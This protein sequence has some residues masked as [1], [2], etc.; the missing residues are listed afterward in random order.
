[1]NEAICEY[2]SAAKPVW[3]TQRKSP[4]LSFGPW[5]AVR[6][7]QG[8]CTTYLP[9][10]FSLAGKGQCSGRLWRLWLVCTDWSKQR[11]CQRGYE[12][13]F[14]QKHLQQNVRSSSSAC[15]W[16]VWVAE[17][18]LDMAFHF[19]HR[20]DFFYSGYKFWGVNWCTLLPEMRQ[21]IT[22]SSSS[23][24]STELYKSVCQ[25]GGDPGPTELNSGK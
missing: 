10:A 25:A 4:H 7:D 20:K 3:W 1:M 13:I 9:T 19:R 11:R 6:Q 14:S 21:V 18:M 22:T 5:V 16:F 8:W 12:K 23:L 2:S 15:V 17:Q 24:K